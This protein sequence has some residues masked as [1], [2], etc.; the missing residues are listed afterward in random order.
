MPL[1]S[2]CFVVGMSPRSLNSF[3]KDFKGME[4]GFSR[5]WR[6]FADLADFRGFFRGKI[7]DNGLQTLSM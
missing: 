1:S 5:I 4:R 6:I 3:L 2:D 7:Y